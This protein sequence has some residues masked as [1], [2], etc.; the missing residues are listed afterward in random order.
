MIYCLLSLDLSNADAQQ[1]R[2]FNK[3]LVENLE[4]KKLNGVDTVWARTFNFP[5]ATQMAIS[6]VAGTIDSQLIGA[7]R[8]QSIS[9]LKYVVQI[10]NTE[11]V[12]AE[13]TK[14]PGRYTY[15]STPYNPY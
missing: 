11:V 15:S 5:A 10:A 13:I 9:S 8:E 14:L 3:D 2:D 1:R 7:V 4:W 12:A 6:S